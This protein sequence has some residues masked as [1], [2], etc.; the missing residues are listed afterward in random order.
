MLQAEVARVA[1]AAPRFALELLKS[2]GLLREF[3]SIHVRP[4]DLRPPFCR[5]CR[6]AGVEC[7]AAKD[8]LTVIAPAWRHALDR[9]E[10]AKRSYKQTLELLEVAA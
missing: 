1:I 3:A 5:D 7:E 6:A 9:V 2:L 4:E 8:Q 10:Q